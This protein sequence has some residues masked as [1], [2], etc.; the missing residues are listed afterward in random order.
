MRTQFV[1]ILLLSC[2]SYA[3]ETKPSAPASA[4]LNGDE[5]LAAIVEAC[6]QGYPHDFEGPARNSKGAIVLRFKGREFLYDEGKSKS[7]AEMLNASDVKD[8][9]SETYPLENP[10][11]K[12]PE[13]FDPGRFRVEELS[14]RS[15]ARP[16]LK[17]CATA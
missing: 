1:L 13:N 9:F 4:A 17:L 15:M 8:T 10:I 6:A 3:Q 2:G 12:L 14:K 7:F 16:S 5:K 11:D